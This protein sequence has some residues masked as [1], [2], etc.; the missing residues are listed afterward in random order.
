V[1]RK[2]AVE[3][4]VLAASVIALLLAGLSGYRSATYARCQAGVNEQLVKATNA[5]AAAAEQDRDAMDQ[6]VTD[7]SNA[8]T[9][10]DSRNALARY[11]QTRAKA[12]QDRRDHPLPSPPSEHC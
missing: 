9:A 8:K 7:V 4:A 1:I 5:R 3:W 10:D 12:D 11:R 6:L 2:S